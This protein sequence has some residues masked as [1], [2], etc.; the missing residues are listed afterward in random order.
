MS[1]ARA[2]AA[3]TSLLPE[4]WRVHLPVFE[5]PLDLL[6]HLI[7]IDEVEITDIPVA[8]ICDQ[9]HEYLNHMEELSL[10]IAGDYIFM[11][12]YLIH[13][14]SKMLL[15]RPKTLDGEVIDED[16]REDLVARLIEYRRLKDAAM[17]LAEVDSV[18]RGM[19]QRR[20]GDLRALAA[21]DDAE[22]AA[23]DI[24]EISLFDLLASLRV[25][26]DRFSR[27]HPEPLHLIG[28]TFSVRD[29]LDRLLD[30]LDPGR[31]YDLLDDMRTLSG[32]REMIAA[33]LAVLEMA[34]MN[35]VRIHQTVAGAVLLYRTTRDVGLAELEAIQG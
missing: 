20:G 34:R 32:R 3:G 21:A 12:A 19:W 6:L 8:R 14:K 24:G 7:K 17:S 31:P 22:G 11:A 25:V 23:I 4:T 5:G 15:P 28:E 16:P 35:L 29:Q 1:N 13:L 33:F 18:R 10:D 26:M 27:E 9:F 30:R 2:A